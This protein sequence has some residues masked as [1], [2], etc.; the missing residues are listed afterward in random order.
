MAIPAC[1]AIISCSS[2][3]ADLKTYA[4]TLFLITDKTREKPCKTGLPA[5]RPIS[6]SDTRKYAN[7]NVNPGFG[8]VQCETSVNEYP[9]LTVNPRYSMSSVKRDYS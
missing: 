4:E 5:V 6:D 8:N 2:I 1:T 9:G 3:F 7:K